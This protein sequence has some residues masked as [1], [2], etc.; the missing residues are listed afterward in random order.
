MCAPQKMIRAGTGEASPA[1]HGGSRHKPK[2]FKRFSLNVSVLLT[3]LLLLLAVTKATAFY[4][5]QAGRWLNLDPL[6][7]AGGINLYQYCYNDPINHIDPNGLAPGDPYPTPLAAALA[8]LQDI[9]N[10]P[11]TDANGNEVIN[12]H[13]WEFA[14]HVY[15]LP[16]KEGDKKTYSY[17]EPK[18]GKSK[19]SSNPFTDCKNKPIMTFH[20]HPRDVLGDTDNPS[21]A[22]EKLAKE[23][24]TQVGETYPPM[25]Q[26]IS[27]PPV[28]PKAPIP[29]IRVNTDGSVTPNAGTIQPRK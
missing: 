28:D 29:V 8:G 27:T 21:P 1:A 23:G 18:A 26:A 4:D 13:I 6:G 17:S 25:P 19:N 15:E 22:D 12:G 14:G 24:F 16:C 11:A 7:E 5:P 9:E 2:S 10:L 20:N 3:L